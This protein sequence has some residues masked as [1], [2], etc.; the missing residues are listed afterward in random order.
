MAGLSSQAAGDQAA[1]MD[2]IL[3][4]HLFVSLA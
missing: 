2:A 1:L 4:I 3:D